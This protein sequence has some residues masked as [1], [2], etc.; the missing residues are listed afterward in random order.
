MFILLFFSFSS[1]LKNSY[2]YYNLEPEGIVDFDDELADINEKQNAALNQILEDCKQKVE[3]FFSLNQFNEK[4]KDEVLMQIKA[5]LA[6]LKKSKKQQENEE[7]FCTKY[8]NNINKFLKE[9]KTIKKS[10]T[11]NNSSKNSFHDELLA[12]E[13]LF[14][15]KIKGVANNLLMIKE[16]H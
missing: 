3:L 14:R 13:E 8:Y 1:P 7:K 11:L 9:T 5:I 16:P 2:D 6:S 10:L 12:L 4:K 15:H